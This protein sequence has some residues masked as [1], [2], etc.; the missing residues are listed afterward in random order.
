MS[1]TRRCLA[2]CACA[3][4]LLALGLIAAYVHANYPLALQCIR[5][6]L[7][8]KPDARD[9]VCYLSR[10]GTDADL[11]KWRRTGARLAGAGEW[12]RIIFSRGIT[13]SGIRLTDYSSGPARVRDWSAY[14]WLKW[15]MLAQQDSAQKLV[16][17]VKDAGERRFVRQY[18]I[19]RGTAVAVTVDLS[20]MVPMIDLTRV[21]ELHYYVQNPEEEIAVDLKDLRLERGEG[22]SVLGMPFVVFGGMEAPARTERGRTVTIYL[23]LSVARPQAIPY[24]LFIHLFPE[25]ERNV[26]IPARRAGYLHAEYR[27]FVPVTQWAPMEAQRLGPYSFFLPRSVPAGNYLIEAGLFNSGSPGDGPRGVV[28]RGAYDYSGSFPKCRYTDPALN[29]FTVGSL[30]V[31]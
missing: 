5:L 8:E 16:L 19:S 27:P 28:Y 25:R 22:G 3:L 6:L 21:A 10:F 13:F 15:E 29:D 23:T 9:G 18:P 26:P 31:D 11:E 1:A 14:R 12:G 2:L 24:S 7:Y 17:A 4:P 30:L 20:A